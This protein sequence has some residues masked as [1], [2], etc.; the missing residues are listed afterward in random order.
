MNITVNGTA[1]S[2]KLPDNTPLLWAMPDD[3]ASTGVKDDCGIAKCGYCQ[4]GQIMQTMDL[5]AVNPAPTDEDLDDVMSKN[6][7]R[8]ATYPQIRAAIHDAAAVMREA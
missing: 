7:Y 2:V 6:L 5:L 3:L 4:S 1:H 8:C